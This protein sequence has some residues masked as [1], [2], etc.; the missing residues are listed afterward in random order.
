MYCF[1]DVEVSKASLDV[2]DHA[3]HYQFVVLIDMKLHA[4]NQLYNSIIFWDIRVLKASVGMPDHTHLNLHDQFITLIDMMLHAQNQLY[5]FFSF[6]N[7]KVL[8]AS[9]DMPRHV[10]P[11]SCKST[12]SNQLYTSNCFWDIKSLK[13]L[14]SAGPRA[15][16]HLTQKTDF[17]QTC[18]FNSII[19]AIMVH[20]LN[21]KNL[22]INGLFFFFFFFAKSKKTY[23]RGVSGC[24][25]QNEISSRK[26][27]SL[28]FLPFGGRR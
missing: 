8:I 17:S 13:I 9:M 27:S 1:W 23:F 11:H 18:S 21:Q 5:A 28:S 26:S 12:S 10:W 22:Y 19:N 3:R 4:K 14:Q 25:P 6:W 24:S 7:V 2:P 20:D 15:F 16:L